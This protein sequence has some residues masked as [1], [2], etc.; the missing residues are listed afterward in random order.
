M[1]EPA[2]AFPPLEVE[3]ALGRASSEH[4]GLREN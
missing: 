1:Q 4:T 2:Q 3:E